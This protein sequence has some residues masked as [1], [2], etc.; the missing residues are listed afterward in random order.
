MKVGDEEGYVIALGRISICCNKLRQKPLYL[1]WFPPQDE[2][3]LRSLC[4][5][6]SE[7]VNEYVLNF[8]RLLYP[9]A[10]SYAVDAGFYKHLFILVAGYRKRV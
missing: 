8:V 9:Y 2:E 3:C 7:F 1:Y 10:Y 5:E 4:Q 6:S